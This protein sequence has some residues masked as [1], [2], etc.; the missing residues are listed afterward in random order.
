MSI[1]NELSVEFP[2]S[3]DAIEQLMLFDA[4]FCDLATAYQEIN[5]RIFRIESL[6]EPAGPDVL[7]DLKRHRSLLKDEIAAAVAASKCAVA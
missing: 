3:W 7:A 6:E 4:V 1:P 2:G 5:R